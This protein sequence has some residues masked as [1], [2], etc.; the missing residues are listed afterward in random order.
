MS[1]A[2]STSSLS[3]N[4]RRDSI[5]DEEGRA[6]PPENHGEMLL[7]SEAVMKGYVGNSTDQTVF[8]RDGFVRTGDRGYFDH[9]GRLYLVGRVPRA[10]GS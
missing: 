2:R 5:R 10:A 7:R 6:L 8:S 4:V 9:I 3:A 1:T